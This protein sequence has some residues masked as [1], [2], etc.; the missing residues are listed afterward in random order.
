MM[1]ETDLQTLFT[2]AL[3][4]TIAGTVT[5]W[6]VR[7][8]RQRTVG[9]HS[10]RGIPGQKRPAAVAHPGRVQTLGEHDSLVRQ[11]GA[12]MTRAIERLMFGGMAL[13]DAIRAAA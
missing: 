12:K 10:S 6:G 7:N 5:T 2:A 13:E 1:F 9:K 4:A 11:F 3:L 8:S